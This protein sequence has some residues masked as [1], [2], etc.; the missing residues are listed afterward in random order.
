MA[1]VNPHEKA[2]KVIQVILLAILY[3]FLYLPVFYI[4]YLSFSED[5]IWPFPPRLTVQ[6]YDHLSIMRDVKEGLANSLLI[7]LGS[8][9]VSTG[10]A[11]AAAI[12][13]L[14]YN[15][16][17]RPLVI[18]I[19]IAPLFVAQILI[20]I[21]SLMYN[22]NV[23]GLPGNISSA[24][25]SNAVFSL[26]FAFLIIV[27]QVARY[28]WRL[29]EAAQVFGARPLRCF[30][31]VTLPNIWPAILGAFL[32]SFIMGFNNFEITFYNVAAVPTLPTIAW[33]SLRHGIQPELFAIATMVNGLVFSALFF[34]YILLR[35]NRLRIGLPE[36]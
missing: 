32:V 10:L 26:S 17:S 6:W 11:A 33:G 23:L 30:W 8:A 35:T 16:R 36:N 34:L 13:V 20:G 14:R 12:G 25:I 9:A 29:D 2:G 31:E 1:V 15:T 27:A 5:S 28:D 21:S 4:A 7:G 22:R 3:V 18:A 19:Y 24:V